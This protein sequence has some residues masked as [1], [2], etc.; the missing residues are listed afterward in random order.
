MY[1]PMHVNFLKVNRGGKHQKSGYC[2]TLQAV[3]VTVGAYD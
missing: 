3:V 1:T 2:I